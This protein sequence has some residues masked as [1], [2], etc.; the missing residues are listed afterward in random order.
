MTTL[1]VGLNNDPRQLIQ[2]HSLQKLKVY[3]GWLGVCYRSGIDT[4]SE[5]K[6]R[7]GSIQSQQQ[8]SLMTGM[9]KGAFSLSY[10]YT[11]GLE[12]IQLSNFAGH[13]FTLGIDIFDDAYRPT[14]IRGIL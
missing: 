14:T 2:I 5:N 4:L 12:R 10:A 9:Q 7:N 11:H 6:V 8:L 13:L 3:Y 1:V